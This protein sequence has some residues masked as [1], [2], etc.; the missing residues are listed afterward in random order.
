MRPSRLYPHR[1][2]ATFVA[3]T[4]DDRAVDAVVEGWNELGGVAESPLMPW[5]DA[6]VR[7]FLDAHAK[8]VGFNGLMRGFP[9]MKGCLAAGSGGVGRSRGGVRGAT[10]GTRMRRR[11]GRMGRRSTVE[12][13]AELAA[14]KAQ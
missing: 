10:G 6:H 2:N 13:A 7:P 12:A 4:A 3:K 11:G 14:M 9:R 5:Y 1:F 8:G